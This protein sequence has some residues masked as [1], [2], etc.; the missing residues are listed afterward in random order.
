VGRV[1]LRLVNMPAILL[2]VAFLTTGEHSIF[3]VPQAYPSE[4]ECAAA[5]Q[6][7]AQVVMRNHPEVFEV[8]ATCVAMP[9]PEKASPTSFPDKGA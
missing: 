1:V 2:L 3:A 6:G 9:A 8:K 4:E 7:M 5:G